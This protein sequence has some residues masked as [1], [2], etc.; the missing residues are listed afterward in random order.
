M[1]IIAIIFIVAIFF[2]YRRF[3]I[4]KPIF[5]SQ[6]LKRN[7]SVTGSYMR[8]NLTFSYRD[9]FIT[10]SEY[11]GSKYQSAYTRV[12]TNVKNPGLGHIKIYSETLASEIGKKLGKQDIQIGSSEFDEKFM[13]KGTDEHFVI[14]LLTSNIQDKLLSLRVYGP[15]VTLENN[16]L[17][18]NVPRVLKTDE[19]YDLLI[20]TI[21]IIIDRLIEIQ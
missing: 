2:T 5:E 18:V 12:V 20:D 4:L 11:P 17:K 16:E 8:Y 6:A 19:A 9:S 14:N 10:V 1:L 13:I 21:L 15:T 7:G 3:A